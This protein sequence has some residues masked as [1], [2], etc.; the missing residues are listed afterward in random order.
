M[1]RFS[2]HRTPLS[3]KLV[4]IEKDLNRLPH[5]T[6]EKH[7]SG[8]ISPTNNTPENEA[9]ISSLREILYIYAQEHPDIGYRQG[10]HE[11]ASFLLFV[12]ELE[13]QQY[14]DH[15]LFN[16]ILPICYGLLER[17]LGQLKTAYDATG[18][19][20]LQQMSIAI[21]GKILQN[22]PTLYH[23]LTSNPNIPPPP[24]Y[25]TR[26]VRLMFSREV[27]GYENV[28]ELWDVFFS[29]ANVMQALEIASASRILLLGDA[30]LKPDNSTLD[31]LMNVPPMADITPLTNIL[32]KL[33]QQKEGDQ[34]VSLPHGLP[35]IVLEH[36]QPPPPTQQQYQ[37]QY[38]GMPLPMPVGGSMNPHMDRSSSDA[39]FSFSKMR[40]SFGQKVDSFG[41]KLANKT[42]EWTEA[43]RREASGGSMQSG[44]DSSSSLSF[45]PLGGLLTHSYNNHHPHSGAPSNSSTNNTSNLMSG[46]AG[47]IHGSTTNLA[48]QQQP[49]QPKTPK[50]HQHEMWS[51]MLQ[52]KILT[53]Q[54]FL[55][56]LESKEN[57]GTV[58]PDVWEA[59]A[60]MDRMQRELLNYSRNM[61]GSL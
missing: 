31:L 47:A 48:L 46:F 52:Q 56:A 24:I 11:I 44:P 35:A 2:H 26:W 51:Q 4:I 20:S 22:D 3:E 15:I 45:D 5:P 28:F 38:P 1:I 41:Q 42:M 61:A 59:L 30:L 19:K 49:P 37:Q 21:L 58:P 29:Y 14:P 18:G 23:H 34:A 60:D 50:Q 12:L 17:T 6:E 8:A 16:P 57:K 53:V 36:F 13:H 7:P 25:C 40:Q 39:K 43:A 33:M 27:V 10:M 54:E 55:M 9:R 32:Q